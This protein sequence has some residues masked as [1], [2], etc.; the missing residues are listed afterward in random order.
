MRAHAFR[1]TPG[2][3]L[4]DELARL[5]KE[6]ALRAG[7]ILSCVGSLS[8]TPPHAWP[9]RRGGVFQVVR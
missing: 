9:Y 1:L 5:T 7:C 3:D 2:D 6:H 8:R 4:K